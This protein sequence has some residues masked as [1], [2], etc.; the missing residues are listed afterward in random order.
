MLTNLAL[1]LP[2]PINKLAFTVFGFTRTNTTVEPQIRPTSGRWI[3]EVIKQRNNWTFNSFGAQR[4]GR[5]NEVVVLTGKSGVRWV[6][7]YE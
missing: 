3:N 2:C 1:V 6:P 5:N 7:L 4:R